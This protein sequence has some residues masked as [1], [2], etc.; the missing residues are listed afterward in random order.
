MRRG[1][2]LKTFGMAVALISLASKPLLAQPAASPVRVPA[3]AEYFALPPYHLHT[4]PSSS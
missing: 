4:T 1:P 2:W 3:V